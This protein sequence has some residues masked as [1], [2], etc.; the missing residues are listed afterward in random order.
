ML[1]LAGHP[2]G[3]KFMVLILIQKHPAQVGA[4]HLPYSFTDKN[5]LGELT[6]NATLLAMNS[7]TLMQIRSN[8][9]NKELIFL[10]EVK[11]SEPLSIDYVRKE[12]SGIWA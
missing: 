4:E 6:N 7:K 8:G 9:W 2:L 10:R 5:A 11:C 12:R 1:V 3:F